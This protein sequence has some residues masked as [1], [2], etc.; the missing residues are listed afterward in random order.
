[1]AAIEC[2]HSGVSPCRPGVVGGAAAEVGGGGDGEDI[3]LPNL[4][5]QPDNPDLDQD[6]LPMNAGGGLHTH[7]HTHTPI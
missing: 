4:P 1:M 7:T 6:D 3:D 2:A 5:D